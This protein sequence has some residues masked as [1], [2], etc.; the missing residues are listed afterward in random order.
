MGHIRAAGVVGTGMLITNGMAGA[1][2]SEIMAGLGAGN[3]T[4]VRKIQQ[5]LSQIKT[6]SSIVYATLG[7]TGTVPGVP[8]GSSS[9]S[10][11]SF[12]HLPIGLV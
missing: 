2:E 1:G 11:P 12:N 10:G 6:T 9:Q 4:V 7:I 5:A 8:H 3:G